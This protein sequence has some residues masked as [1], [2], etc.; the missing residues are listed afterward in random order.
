MTSL[1]WKWLSC[2]DATAFIDLQSKKLPLSRLGVGIIPFG[3]Y[4]HV[5]CGLQC[6]VIEVASFIYSKPINVTIMCIY[7]TVTYTV[8]SEVLCLWERTWLIRWRICRYI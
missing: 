1:G 2:V 4:L 7:W 8:V 6:G 5:S 3:L